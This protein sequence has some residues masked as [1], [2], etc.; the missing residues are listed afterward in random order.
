LERAELR[1]SS[2][3]DLENGTLEELDLL[4]CWMLE[5]GDAEEEGREGGRD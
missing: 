2:S 4:R 5:C 3:T 1:E